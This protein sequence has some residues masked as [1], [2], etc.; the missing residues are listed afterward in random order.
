V[1]FL[2]ILATKFLVLKKA[3]CFFVIVIFIFFSC[4]PTDKTFVVDKNRQASQN[5]TVRIANEALEY[6]IMIIDPGFN[7]WFISYAR[8]RNFYSQNYLEGRNRIWVIEWNLRASQPTL[9][10]ASLFEMQINYQPSIDYGYEVNYML[11]NYLTYFQLTNRIK[12][13]GFDARI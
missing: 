6:E 2:V 5:D 7:N 8:P 12:L 3:F 9:Y 11:F 13:G 10:N 1:L 4:K